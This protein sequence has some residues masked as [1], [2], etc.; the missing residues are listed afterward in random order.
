MIRTA[1]CARLCMVPVVIEC[2]EWL[3]FAVSNRL[4]SSDVVCVCVRSIGEDPNCISHRKQPYNIP[5]TP[6]HL[7]FK[8]PQKA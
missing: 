1:F 6:H 7:G 3:M 5:N 2:F 8:K 4:Q